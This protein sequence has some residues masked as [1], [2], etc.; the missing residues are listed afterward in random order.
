MSHTS[1]IP[2]DCAALSAIPDH[3]LPSRF[4]R[5]RDSRSSTPRASSRLRN[6]VSV[7]TLL[8]D[9]SGSIDAT[10]EPA[11]EATSSD[12]QVECND[13]YHSSLS[14]LGLRLDA[15]ERKHRRDMKEV[16]ADADKQA[17]AVN[18]LLHWLILTVFLFAASLSVSL[19]R[20]KFGVVL[21]SDPNYVIVRL[22]LVVAGTKLLISFL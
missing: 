19:I 4:R 10:L 20:S 12:S 1:M 14:H 13:D 6:V 5:K 21:E 11:S 7:E 3:L 2:G 22:F 18:N 9:I 15:L 16:H 17:E 8:G